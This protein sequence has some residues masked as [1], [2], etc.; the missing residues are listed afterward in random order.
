QDEAP[1]GIWSVG[2]Y[3][4]DDAGQDE[5]WRRFYER[6][7]DLSARPGMAGSADAAP[8]ADKHDLSVTN[9]PLPRGRS[10]LTA[11]ENLAR[12]VRIAGE[13]EHLHDEGA[14][15]RDAM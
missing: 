2:G 12:V 15:Y 14:T 7:R 9:D 10:K 13:V 5:E 11:P 1:I 6:G 4:N 3:P 8:S